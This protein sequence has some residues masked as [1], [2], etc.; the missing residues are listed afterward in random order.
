MNVTIHIER[1]V[2][3]GLPVGASEGPQVQAAVAVELERLVR[4]HGLAEGIRSGGPTPRLRGTDLRIAHEAPARLGQ[5]I[6]RSVFGGIG[7]AE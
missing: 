7:K 2:L 5:G 3:E 1:L 6:A 4:T